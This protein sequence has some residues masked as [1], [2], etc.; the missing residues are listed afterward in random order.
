MWQAVQFDEVFLKLWKIIRRGPDQLEV[1]GYLAERLP[2]ALG[3]ATSC[4][5]FVILK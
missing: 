5:C 4:Y 1:L 2:L 3:E